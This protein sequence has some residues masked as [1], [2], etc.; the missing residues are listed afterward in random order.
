MAWKTWLPFLFGAWL[1]SRGEF[2]VSF[3]GS[4]NS[5]GQISGVSGKF[6]WPKKL[7]TWRVSHLE[8]QRFSP[9]KWQVIQLYI[10]L[11]CFWSYWFC[12]RSPSCFR[13]KCWKI[14]LDRMVPYLSLT[15]ATTWVAS[16]CWNQQAG[17]ACHCWFVWR[18]LPRL[19]HGPM[20]DGGLDFFQSPD[21]LMK[22]LYLWDYLM[23]FLSGH[24]NLEFLE[25]TEGSYRKSSIQ[26]GETVGSGN[27]VTIN[28]GYW[29][30]GQ[31]SADMSY[32]C[33]SWRVLGAAGDDS[34]YWC[35]DCQQFG[36][37]GSSRFCDP[38]L[39]RCIPCLEDYPS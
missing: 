22:G 17:Q 31:N 14:H 10:C 6:G 4:V 34:M 29:G 33:R 12:W 13:L 8:T 3:I 11:R 21:D 15:C 7:A 24:L 9:F 16:C 37:A 5:L 38:K 32:L 25:K 27:Q 30:R 35:S 36:G 20:E 19:L 18:L 28:L 2:A 1:I 26:N 23:W 39:W